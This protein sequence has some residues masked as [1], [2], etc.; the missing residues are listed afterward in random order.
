LATVT[1]DGV[2]YEADPKENLLHVALSQG[3]DLPYFCWHPA[4]GSVG[5]C[6]QC[7]V[8]QFQNE[9]DTAGRI[10]MA[11]MTPATEGARIAIE[12]PEAIEFRASVI[13]WLMLNHPHDCPVCDEGGECHLQDMTLM[14]GH[15]YRRYRFN[16]RTYRNQYLGPFLTHEMNRCIQCYRC[17]RFYRDF[18][19]GEDLDVFGAH[20]R[21][22]FGRHA[23]GVLESEFSGNLAEVCPTGVFTDKAFH[24]HY[25]RKWDLQTAPSVC[26]HC[27]LGC[28]TIPGER[29]GELRRIRNR[30]NREVNG[31]FICDRGRFGYGFVNSPD[32]LREPIRR[33]TDGRGFEALAPELA[34]EQLAG[35]LRG[36]SRIIGIGSP[37]A[38][39]ESNYA[40]RALVGPENFFSGISAKESRLVA[41]VIE[42]LSN[43]PARS[44]SLHEVE[45]ADAV[46]IL[47]E[48][49][50]N[51]APMLDFAVRQ[52]VRNQPLAIPRQ[53]GIPDWNEGA[54]RFTIQDAKGPLFV[55]TPART[56]LDDIATR[57]FRM[58]PD[59]LARLGF[60]VAHAL[61]PSTPEVMGLSNETQA[62]VEEIAQALRSAGRPLVISGTSLGSESL[63]H[64][65]ADV[66][67]ALHVQGRPAE[68]SLV[69]PE[70]NSLG[71]GLMG[72]QD[73]EAARQA[74]TSGQAGTLIVL[75]NDLYRRAPAAFV[76]SLLEAARQVIV[77]DHLNTPT[78][79]RAGMAFPAAT[80]AE[81]D[82]T[83][84]NN[85]G[86]AQ[87][88]YQVFVP[89][90]WV[91]ESWR[92]LRDIGGAAGLPG[93]ESWENL[94]ALLADLAAELPFLAP[95]LDVSP[96]ADFRLAD[97]K[98]PRQPH[99]YSGRTAMLS[100]LTVHEPK[101]PED[102]DAPFSFSMEGF[103]GKPFGNLIPRYWEPGWNSVQA[104][105]KYQS[106][107][108]G[109]LLGGDPGV[110]LF[111]PPAEARGAYYAQP[112]A[113]FQPV[114]GEWLL[115]PLYHIYGSEEL[116]SLS[117]PVAELVPGPYLAVSP[118]DAGLLGLAAGLPAR[119]TF[120]G[121]A[122]P[123]DN[124]P[125]YTPQPHA[126][127]GEPPPYDANPNEISL[128]DW[129][130]RV[131]ENL[132]P[133]VG[134]GTGDGQEAVPGVESSPGPAIYFR[135]DVGGETFIL[136][137]RIDPSLPSRVA[138]L[139]AGLPG[140]PSSAI[141]F[142]A[143]VRL[144]PVTEGEW[145]EAS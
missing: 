86:R 70:C 67:R 7:A 10:V 87:R 121:S 31:Y 5:A 99:R 39:L 34:L 84:V 4:M 20:D 115:V 141:L 124:R 119:E 80:F 15:V 102:P 58:A 37:R 17:V 6:R 76:D 137:A 54:V 68:I 97:Q 111:E 128:A 65:A 85:E 131:R 75:E 89:P 57:T 127:S 95:I 135:L 139:P 116:S 23:E 79:A 83:L 50:T 98:I 109:P 1:I 145:G 113:P 112:P 63:L 88:F 66:A 91:Q 28:N 144:T 14:T 27:S 72:G 33:G 9:Q 18:A 100:H 56:K 61:D 60:A 132:E 42:I 82:G 43:S 51:T 134:G 78:V 94:D 40:L 136:P 120:H 74:L 125:V 49:L 29:Y 19:G 41:A 71:L 81:G 73:L 12:D 62:Q 77:V 55:A 114:D 122:R 101:P 123:G 48:D 138:G 3:L 32:R 30:Y 35:D 25:T 105:N 143:L 133:T 90:G 104:L 47:G 24:R 16:K 96:P 13:E 92:W 108:A 52:S 22:Y 142:P 118:S 38:S 130:D 140:S 106:E 110:R 126:L 59:D 36:G 8:K 53:L 44:A 45:L 2:N 46:L 64:A 26:V 93:A 21:V 11:C 103:E 69:V 107:V 117:P 129:A